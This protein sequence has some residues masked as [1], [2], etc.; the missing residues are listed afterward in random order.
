MSVE[1]TKIEIF[2]KKPKFAQKA[3]HFKKAKN[4]PKKTKFLQK[5]PPLQLRGL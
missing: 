3:K 2:P 1:V 4:L 5:R